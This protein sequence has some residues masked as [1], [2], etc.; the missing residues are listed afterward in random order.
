MPHSIS[1][2]CHLTSERQ[3]RMREKNDDEAIKLLDSCH[4]QT[5]GDSRTE[6]SVISAGFEITQFQKHYLMSN[7]KE[8]CRCNRKSYNFSKELLCFHVSAN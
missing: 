7:R 1:I 5:T 3:T 2:W 6:R 4:C 8:C